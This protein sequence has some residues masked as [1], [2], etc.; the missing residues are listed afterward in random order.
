MTDIKTLRDAEKRAKVEVALTAEFV[1]IE[2]FDPRDLEVWLARL[3]RVGGDVAA[4][5]R[6]KFEG[7]SSGKIR[8]VA[9]W[10]EW[11][12]GPGEQGDGPGE[13]G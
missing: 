5:P 10:T 6:I 2:S 7:I 4:R 1:L 13:Q 11:R 8:L 3:P 12:D 9:R